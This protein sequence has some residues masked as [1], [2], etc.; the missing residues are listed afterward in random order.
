MSKKYFQNLP[1]IFYDI[2]KD[3][4]H[5]EII[6]IFNRV[7]VHR[8]ILNNDM[9]TYEYTIKEGDTPENIAN[10][11]YEDVNL[12]WIVLMSNNIIDIYSEWPLTYSQFNNYI[13]KKYG[14]SQ[15]ANRTI[16]AYYDPYGN[17]IDRDYYLEL[18][19][20]E[21]IDIPTTLTKYQYEEM[22]NNEKRE[23]KLLNKNFIDQFLKEFEGAF[24]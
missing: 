6:N 11:Y 9:L 5:K 7:R 18:L 23:I 1:K 21:K 4:K 13:N 17:E 10:R 22:V 24:K 14:S 20:T 19:E 16:H 12:H 15:E 8:S 3:G 2:N